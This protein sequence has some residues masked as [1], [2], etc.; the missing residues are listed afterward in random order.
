[1]YIDPALE[2]QL[3]RDPAETA[4]V[5]IV[6]STYSAAIQTELERAGLHVTSNEQAGQ[7]LVYGRIRLSDLAKIKGIAEIESI[8]IDSTQRIL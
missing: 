2:E 4:D 1:M 3:Q 6:C 8:E 5:V 7:G